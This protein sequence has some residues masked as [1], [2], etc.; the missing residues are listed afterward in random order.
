MRVEDDQEWKVS[1]NFEESDH[2]LFKGT[3][4]E[5]TRTV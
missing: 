2:S 5:F 1:K 3:I 4:P